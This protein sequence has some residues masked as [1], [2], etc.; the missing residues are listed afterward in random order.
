MISIFV[1]VDRSH[2]FF[3]CI[4][5]VCARNEQKKHIKLHNMLQLGKRHYIE[6]QNI[7]SDIDQRIKYMNNTKKNAKKK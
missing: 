3:F 6:K 5:R 7:D 2:E 4:F 1:F